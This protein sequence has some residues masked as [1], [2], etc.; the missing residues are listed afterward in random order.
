MDGKQKYLISQPAL[1]IAI[2]QNCC[3]LKR[4]FNPF[5]KP[6]KQELAMTKIIIHTWDQDTTS[7]NSKN[8]PLSFSITRL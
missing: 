2:Y 1:Q 3:D 7:R 5:W 4:C 8:H 6:N